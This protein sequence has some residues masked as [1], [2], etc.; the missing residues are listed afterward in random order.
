MIVV[1]LENNGARKTQIVRISNVIFN[2]HERRYNAADVIINPGYI[3]PVEKSVLI[4]VHM[5][6]IVRSKDTRAKDMY[7]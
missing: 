6:R 1:K 2:N 4:S 7:I 3:V 5:L